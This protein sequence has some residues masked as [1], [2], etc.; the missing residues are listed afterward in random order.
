MC[1]AGTPSIEIIELVVLDVNS[2]IARAS[3][4]FAHVDMFEPVG[5]APGKQ[6]PPL[7]V[8][9]PADER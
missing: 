5:D 3:V 4:P 7:V 2:A 6:L 8:E 1:I 9:C